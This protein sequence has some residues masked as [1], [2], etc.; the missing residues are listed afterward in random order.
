MYGIM[1]TGFQ[2][3]NGCWYYFNSTGAM[4]TGWLLKEGKYYFLNSDGSMAYGWVNSAGKWY[5][6]DNNTGVMLT[7]TYTPDGRYVS[8]EGELVP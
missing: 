8:A 1:Q 2:K 4:Q 5:Y 7:N 3:V 6:L